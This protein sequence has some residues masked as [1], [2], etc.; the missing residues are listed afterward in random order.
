MGV[1]ALIL[2]RHGESTGNVA[3]EEAEAQGAE[4]IPV[5]ARDADVGLTE[6]GIQ[7]ARHLGAFLRASSPETQPTAV[8]TSPYARARQT[9]LE[10]VAAAGM[11]GRPRVDER[12]RDKE[13]GIL[14]TLTTTGVRARY[15]LEDQRRRWLGKFYYRAPG[16]ESWAD[17]ALRLRSLLFDLDRVEDGQRVLVVTHDAVITMLRYVCEGLDEE[18]ILRLA[19]SDVLL[20]TGVT[21]LA[22]DASDGSWRVTAANQHDHLLPSFAGTDLRTDHPPELA[23]RPE[24][25]PRPP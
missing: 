7:Q 22:R 25:A 9:A 14:D 13:L 2:V 20:N 10:I 6:L 4:V 16:G 8:W 21:R 24:G 11:P 18:E 15:P 12:L 17:L 5:E 19:R 23:E 3:R 1:A